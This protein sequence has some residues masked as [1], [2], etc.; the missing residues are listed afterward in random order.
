[1]VVGRGR[2][3]QQ[4]QEALVLEP[5]RLPEA[6]RESLPLGPLLAEQARVLAVQPEVLLAPRER[7]AQ[8]TPGLEPERVL[9]A[10]PMVLAERP[11]QQTEP[12]G[13][14]SLG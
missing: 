8:R 13:Y 6:L 14:R 10:E 5:E 3:T 7:L 9:P 1:M 4:A 11:A 2:L 12:V